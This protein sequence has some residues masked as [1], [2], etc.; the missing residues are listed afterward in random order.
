LADQTLRLPTDAANTGQYVDV[1]QLTVGSNTVIRERLVIAGQLAAAIANV[2]N[3]QLAGGEYALPVRAII[4]VDNVANVAHDAVDSG[5][6]NKIG[7]RAKAGLSA[8]TLVS[9]DDRSDIFVG[10]DG[11]LLTRPHAGLE[12]L[13]DGNAS[14]TDGTN[15]QVIAAAG[16]GI[17]QY[18]T[19]V[20]LTNTSA[21]N[22]YVEM[23]SGTTVKATIPLPANGGAIVTFQTP[24]KPNAAN[25]AWNFDPSAATTTVYCTA[26]GFKSKV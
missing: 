22:I 4:D 8:V 9:A 26:A 10:T 12:D 19:S 7:A 13:V 6:P 17:K 21:N 24:L 16:A 3:S 23:K 14:N 15:T 20:I 11:V 25:E 1:E 18:L 2:V 5:G